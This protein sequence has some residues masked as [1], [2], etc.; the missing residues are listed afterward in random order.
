LFDGEVVPSPL[1][2]TVPVGQS[3]EHLIKR[4]IGHSTRLFG[5]V[6]GNRLNALT[7]RGKAV[8]PYASPHSRL[9]RLRS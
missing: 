3:I 1:S 5:Q 4:P 8:P 6:L 9:D 7:L 2:G